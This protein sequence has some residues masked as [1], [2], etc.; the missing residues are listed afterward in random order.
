[1]LAESTAC[2]GAMGPDDRIA[3]AVHIRRIHHPPSARVPQYLCRRARWREGQHGTTCPEILEQLGGN[4]VYGVLRRLE[5]Q[6]YAGPTE[7]R[8]R[9]LIRRARK[10]LHSRT[11]SGGG[12]GL[13][14]LRRLGEW[15]AAQEAESD[16]RRI[17][18]ASFGRSTHC[19]E[20]RA[21]VTKAPTET[22]GMY[23]E[24]FV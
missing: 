20:H 17:H 7:L 10:E 12:D 8:Q 23:D 13:L 6:E 5:Q 18:E 16:P 21:R 24:Q 4:Q 2:P 22:P 14:N 9:G 1:Q 19:L 3:E 11:E 15:A